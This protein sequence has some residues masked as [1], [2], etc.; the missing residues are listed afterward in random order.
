MVL[1]RKNGDPLLVALVSRS[2]YLR[3]YHKVTPKEEHTHAN[4]LT[5]AKYQHLVNAFHE[6]KVVAMKK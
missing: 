4:V 5:N 1:T 6:D 3:C 2:S